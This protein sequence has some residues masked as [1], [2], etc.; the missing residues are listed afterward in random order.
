MA[1]SDRIL[2]FLDDVHAAGIAYPG[3]APPVKVKYAGAAGAPST[4]GGAAS[5]GAGITE[6]DVY[7]PFFPMGVS[8]ARALKD[9][10]D[11]YGP[12]QWERTQKNVEI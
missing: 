8:E 2:Q 10:D 1:D 9:R 11:E 12:F 4:M 3:G 6:D 5:G 7:A